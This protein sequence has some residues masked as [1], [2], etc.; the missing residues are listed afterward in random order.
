MKILQHTPYDSSLRAS[1]RDGIWFSVMLGAAESYLSVLAIFLGGTPLQIALIATLPPLIGALTQLGGVK[2]MERGIA[3]KVVVV[4]GAYAQAFSW[5]L[6]MVLISALEGSPAVW[7]L[8]ACATIYHCVG[9]CIT[10]AWNSLIG[11]LVPTEIRGRYFGYRNWWVGLFTLVSLLLAGICL[12]FARN[13]GSEV[14]GFQLLCLVGFAAR[15]RSAQWLARHSDPSHGT[16]TAH[17]FTFFQFLRR[18][19]RAN[20]ARFVVFFAAMNAAVSIA[21]PFFSL[22]MLRELGM[23]YVLFTVISATQLFFQ[24]VTMQWWGYFADIYGNRKLLVLCASGLCLSPFLWLLGTHP[25]WLV[26]IQAYAGTVWAGYNLAA[27]GFL[28][29]AVTPPKRARCAAFMGVINAAFVFLGALL[30]GAAV[31]TT[32]TIDGVFDSVYLNVFLLSCIARTVVAI[33]LLPTFQEVRAVTPFA[34]REV[35]VRIASIRPSAGASFSFIS[36]SA[37]RLS[38]KP[39]KSTSGVSQKAES[40]R[41]D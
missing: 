20:F 37:R 23:N 35:G 39:D 25:L 11:D 6:I 15:S 7:G 31:Y 40:A 12:H 30:G 19:P 2:L 1:I 13:E 4:R 26:C 8:L 33:V 27:F 36:S 18:L 32:S 14:L 38:T 10:P 21:G 24:F 5:L 34:L 41:L 22:Y 3:R 17:R 28:F 16:A 29:D 9:N